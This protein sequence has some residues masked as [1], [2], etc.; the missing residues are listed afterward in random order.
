[1]SLTLI[2]RELKKEIP[3]ENLKEVANFLKTGLSKIAL[4]EKTG[5]ISARYQLRFSEETRSPIPLGEK[6]GK[7][8][9]W[10]DIYDLWE[11]H[12]GRN[13]ETPF[14]LNTIYLLAERSRENGYCG[15]EYLS[16]KYVLLDEDMEPIAPP[17][18]PDI[19]AEDDEGVIME[20]IKEKALQ[21]KTSPF[22]VALFTKQNGASRGI[23]TGKISWG[24]VNNLYRSK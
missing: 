8:R 1:M 21:Y 5:W 19:K 6:T 3:L 13:P 11:E 4:A 18:F 7:K 15:F 24:M 14:N 16:T 20:K 17:L 22:A 23:P 10:A 12:L 2:D 9:K